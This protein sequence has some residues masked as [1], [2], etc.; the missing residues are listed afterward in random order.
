M[1]YVPSDLV[2]RDV[3]IAIFV[4]A[5]REI[6]IHGTGAS[7]LVKRAEIINTSLQNGDCY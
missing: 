6:A 2:V 4:I 1:R 5:S 7:A 3:H